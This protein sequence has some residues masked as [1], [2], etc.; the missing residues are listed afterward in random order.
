MFKMRFFAT[1]FTGIIC[2]IALTLWVLIPY[3]MES[4]LDLKLRIFIMYVS[5]LGGAGFVAWLAK[6]GMDRDLR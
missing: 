6:I 5:I 3:V 4:A 2:L 1:L